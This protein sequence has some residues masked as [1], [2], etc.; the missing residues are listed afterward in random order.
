MTTI[1]K[2]MSRYRR[3]VARFYYHNGNRDEHN[4]PTLSRE[5]DWIA[6]PV[7]FYCEMQGAGG[8]EKVR[9][10]QV[11]AVTSH[12]LFGEARGITTVQAADRCVIGDK[13]FEVVTKGDPDGL[14]TEG[15][16]ELR[17]EV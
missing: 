7:V 5:S 6:R 1:P 4:N 14:D 3:H 16:I 15:R 10:R 17:R 2:R 13:R 9:G 11:T 8:G 12:V